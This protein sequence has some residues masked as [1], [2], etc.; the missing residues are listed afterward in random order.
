MAE[1][2]RVARHRSSSN[3]Y[4]KDRHRLTPQT[5]DVQQEPR[6]TPSIRSPGRSPFRFF[7]LVFVL[8][9]PL[10]V[11]GALVPLELLPG[12]PVSSLS[13]LCPVTA[14]A[15]LV[16]REDRRTG[17]TELLKRSFDCRRIRAAG[18]YLPIVL[19]MPTVAFLAYG[20]M[21]LTGMPLPV[22]QRPGWTALTMVPMFFVAALG[23]EIGWS[24]YATD[25][26]EE[27]WTALRAGVLLGVVGA[28][29]HLVLLVQAQRPPAWIAWQSLCLIA[30]RVLIVWLYNSTGR[31]VFAAAV[32]HAMYNLSWQLFPNHG[33]HYDPRITGLI[34]TL[35]AVI[36][37]V[38]GARRRWSIP[39]L[40]P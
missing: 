23:E 36:V 12:L 9:A 27:R 4:A 16:Y 28:A 3:Y 35:A 38:A 18:W 22:P 25:P 14:A 1:M 33:S 21:R 2:D 17:V 34:M 10:F 11:M 8:S 19:L 32:C 31:S 30:L 20:L 26:L 37:T 5:S 6:P 24:G 15:I 29:W 13:V 7:L 39:T 40:R